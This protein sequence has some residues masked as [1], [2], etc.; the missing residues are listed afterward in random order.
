[1]PESFLDNIGLRRLVEKIKSNYVPISRTINGKPLSSNI[2]LTADDISATPSISGFASLF[3]SSYIGNGVSGSEE[4][5]NS[6]TAPRPI[7]FIYMLGSD[8]QPYTVTTLIRA[9]QYYNFIVVNK[10]STNEYENVQ[11]YYSPVTYMRAKGKMSSDRKTFS[12]Y[13]YQYQGVPTDSDLNEAQY[14]IQN[15]KYYYI[16]GLE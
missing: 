16:I 8:A 5:A 7:V 14:N 4:N 13:A 3:W 10:I 11:F 9:T 1:M 6:I 2:S 15:K 12:W